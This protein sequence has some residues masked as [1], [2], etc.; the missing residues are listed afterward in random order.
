[1]PAFESLAKEAADC[2]RAED[3]SQDSFERIT[4]VVRA[5]PSEVRLTASVAKLLETD[6][7]AGQFAVRACRATFSVSQVSSDA[8]LL[9]LAV[10]C[11]IA[12]WNSKAAQA[13]TPEIQ[14]W[15]RSKWLGF[16]HS[17]V[18]VTVSQQP[19]PV[20]ALDDTVGRTQ[21]VWAHTLSSESRAPAAWP[22]KAPEG[23]T[24][25]VW[26]VALQVPSSMVDSLQ[27]RLQTLGMMDPEV[28]AF[29][30]RMEALAQEQGAIMAML[31]PTSWAN[32]FSMARA[33]AFRY[34]AQAVSRALPQGTSVQVHF[35]GT[36]L[37]SYTPSGK[38]LSWGSFPEETKEDLVRMLDRVEDVTGLHLPLACIQ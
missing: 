16:D 23:F 36:N 30:Y 8:S 3:C 5:Y 19:I 28:S 37:Y 22:F 33:T 31:P 32:G 25:A 18:K 26:M 9:L 27:M 1:M 35:D 24:A 2:I 13:V 10:P 6:R 15:L 12:K 17:T 11:V 4:E 20:E 38:V 14:G 21:E 29:K 7:L 34:Q